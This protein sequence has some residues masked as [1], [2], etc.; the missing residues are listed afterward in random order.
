MKPS[1]S[2][3]TTSYNSNLEMF[4]RVL[5]SIKAQKY[6]KNLIE[7][8][9][10]DGGSTN[11]LVALA[12]EYGC[13]VVVRKDLIEEINARMY[14][15]VKKAQNEI[16]AIIE[17]DNPLPGTDWLN[18]MTEPFI[19]E[20]NIFCTFNTY[21]FFTKDMSLLTKYCALFGVSDP[22]LYYLGKSEKM[23]W[24]N[25]RYTK[26]KSLKRYEGFTKVLFTPDTLPTLGD[27]GCL[28][29]REIFL[30]TKMQSAS[31]IHLDLFAELMGLG[32]NTF[33]AVDIGIGHITGSNILT[34]IKRRLAF[35]KTFFEK[36]KEERKYL[37]YNPNSLRDKLNLLKFVLFSVTVVEPFIQS[38]RGFIKTRE[39]AWFLHPIMCF[40]FCLGYIKYE[41]ERRM[42]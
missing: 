9:V 22:V 16:I 5:E 42:R 27:N 1:I 3:V 8:I 18:R 26:G 40:L 34:M 23:S 39:M 14:L 7:H 29:K 36:R 41:V 32:Y 35:R 24:H 38:L 20:K 21:N 37:V 10:M 12:K 28:I 33:G 19:K 13:K 2:I 17:T 11:G 30:K 4:R 15:G 25:L 31:F 6:P